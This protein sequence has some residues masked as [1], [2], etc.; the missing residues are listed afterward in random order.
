MIRRALLTV[1]FLLSLVAVL[2]VPSGVS[3]QPAAAVEP[4]CHNGNDYP[5]TPVLSGNNIWTGGQVSCAGSVSGR[6]MQI[7]LQDFSYGGQNCRVVYGG[8]GFYL[9]WGVYTCSTSYLHGYQTYLW[10]YD[11]WDGTTW[12]AWSGVMYAYR[13]MC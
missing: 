12:Q 3:P 7:C 13:R 10:F 2:I 8:A 11:S 6:Q 5:Y 9:N 1:A 4:S